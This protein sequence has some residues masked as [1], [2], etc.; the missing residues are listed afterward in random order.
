MEKT[1]DYR[2]LAWTSLYARQGKNSLLLLY[3]INTKND[4]T[5]III[6]VCIL[7]CVCAEAHLYIFLDIR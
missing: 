5:I 1:T 3:F 7:I 2:T 6:D 4:G